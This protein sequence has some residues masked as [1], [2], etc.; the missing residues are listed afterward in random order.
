MWGKVLPELVEFLAFRPFGF[1]TP[2]LSLNVI[3]DIYQSVMLQQEHDPELRAWMEDN[4]PYLRSLAMLVPA[5]PWELPV[6]TPLWFRR[7][8]E[9]IGE[10]NY[11]AVTGRET[12]DFGGLMDTYFKRT[13][14]EVAG[15]AFGPAI[16]I[17]STYE[18][19]AAAVG[20]VSQ[21]TGAGFNAIVP[22]AQQEGFDFGTPTQA[23]VRAPAPLPGTTEA[24]SPAQGLAASEEQLRERLEEVDVTELE[25]ALDATLAP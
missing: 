17:R 5:L 11:R 14:P 19:G 8:V 13:L 18:T 24:P 21:A 20:L 9:A 25:E 12:K 23:P 10:N 6:N 3:N 2:L 7:A 15:Y 16:G 22:P 1:Q 4:E